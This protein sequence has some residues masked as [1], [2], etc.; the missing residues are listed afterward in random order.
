MVYYFYFQVLISFAF[1]IVSLL[2][3]S[4]N[5]LERQISNAM[6]DI[7][8]SNIEMDF[9]LSSIYGAVQY[10]VWLSYLTNIFILDWLYQPLTIQFILSQP[11]STSSQV[12]S[13][14]I[15][16]CRVL[17][18]HPSCSR[19]RPRLA[20]IYK[21]FQYHHQDMSWCFILV[22]TN[23]KTCLDLHSISRPI[24]RLVLISVSIHL[25]FLQSP[26]FWF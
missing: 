6:Q 14:K 9:S 26:K 17:R 1:V 11:N 8:C 5:L 15:V 20:L 19:P 12:G 23:S 21:L 10:F 18:D 4:I 13:D 25:M 22:E 3:Q 2:Y 16:G 7:I 24:P